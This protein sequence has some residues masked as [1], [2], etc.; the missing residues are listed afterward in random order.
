MTKPT[1]T[2]K[3]RYFEPAPQDINV[4]NFKKVIQSRRSVRN[5][6][7]KPIPAEIL[8][9]C[10]DLALLAPNSSNLQ[11]WTFYVVQ[12]PAKKKQ[13]IKAC[14][15]Q[16]A[17]RT[18]AELIVCVARTDRLDEMAKRNVDEFPLIKLSL[19]EVPA[20][21]QKYYRFIPYNY[22]TG[23]LNALGNFKKVTFKI[24]RT[25]KQVLPVTA[26]KP[27]DSILWAS[28]TTALACENLVLSL[29]AYGFDS[30]MMEGFDEPMVRKIL[31]LGDQQHPIMV[32][33]AGERAED[34]VFYPQYRFNR[35]LF[36]QKV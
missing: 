27:A 8:D 16:F 6:T 18:A 14:M 23:Y 31:N 17:A 15:S 21:I 19:A 30:C 11:P 10:L 25:A 29:R 20:I 34:G 36:I 33:G 9:D 7:D 32:I 28:K 1:K 24:A 12:N 4:E 2:E 22:K 5:F 26:F 35:D 13:L 3:K